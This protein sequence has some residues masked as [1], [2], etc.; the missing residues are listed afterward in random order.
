MHPTL[1][2]SRSCLLFTPKW[3]SSAE[4]YW[5]GE[6]LKIRNP[7]KNASIDPSL[8]APLF[9]KLLQLVGPNHGPLGYEGN[10][11][12]NDKQCQPTKAN[13]TLSGGDDELGLL[14]RLATSIHGQKTDSV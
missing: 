8:L 13:K 9:L 6:Y 14:W 4:C 2:M 12:P 1:L 5:R 10:S 7:G 3:L 11:I